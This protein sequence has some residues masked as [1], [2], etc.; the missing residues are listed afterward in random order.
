M[1]CRESTNMSL[2]AVS[3]LLK[4]HLKKNARTLSQYYSI[5]D[6]TFGFSDHHKEASVLVNGKVMN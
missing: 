2:C 3:R 6:N 5:D 1:Y 4:I